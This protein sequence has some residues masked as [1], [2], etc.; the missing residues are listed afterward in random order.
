MKPDKASG[1]A[2]GQERRPSGCGRMKTVRVVTYNIHHGLGTDGRVDIGRVTDTLSG[3]GGELIGL[4]EVDR[5][6]PRSLFCNQARHM[7]RALGLRHIFGAAI[8]RFPCGRYGNA[9]LSRWPVAGFK[10]HLLPGGGEQRVLLEAEIEMGGAKIVFYCTHLGLKQKD[11][12]KQAGAVLDLITA[13]ERPFILVGD[14][15]A[16]RHSPEFLLL[17]GVMLE[18][19]GMPG[20]FNTY[21]SPDP[22]VQI[23]FVFLSRHWEVVTSYTA[24]SG[25]SDH[26]ALVAELSC[27][28]LCHLHSK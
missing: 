13:K 1:T 5:C 6:L 22:S 3:T 7:G 16:E 27:P 17:S 15:N 23:D 12:L 28:K 10:S 4:Q 9:I 8:R 18:A 21:P 14:F 26:L 2:P 25:A 20:G 19:T 11:R 24:A